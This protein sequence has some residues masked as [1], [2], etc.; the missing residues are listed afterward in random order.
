M[1]RPL[2]NQMV[3]NLSDRELEILALFA[4]GFSNRELADRL[5]LSVNT[6]IWYARQ[7]SGKL[8]VSGR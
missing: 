2:Q 6:V 3:E 4:V 7:I 5:V 1:E 8:G